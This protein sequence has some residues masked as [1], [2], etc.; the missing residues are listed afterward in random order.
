MTFAVLVNLTDRDAT[1]LDPLNGK[2]I[3]SLDVLQSLWGEEGTVYWKR[4]PG[5]TL[6]LKSKRVDPS[7]KTIQKALRVQGLYIGKVDGVLGSNTKRAIRF[8]Q[9]K[10][11][12]KDSSVFTLESYLVLSKAMFKEP[13]GLQMRDL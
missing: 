1:V 3:Y 10:Y 8:F 2:M 12:L 9:Q 13:P 5:I 4:L 11:G 6:P 7:V